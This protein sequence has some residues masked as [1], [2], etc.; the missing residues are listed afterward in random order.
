[1][2][3]P[4]DWFPRHMAAPL[5]EAMTDTPV[6]CILG[7]RQCGKSTLARRAFP[8]RPYYSFDDDTL[9]DRAASDPRGFVAGLPDRPT[10]DEIQRG[11]A[12]LSALKMAVDEAPPAGRLPVAGPPPP[13]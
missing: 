12:L 3:A 13:P 1:M 11:P 4:A 7:P 8:D 9:R 6:V 2:D 10:L 5:V